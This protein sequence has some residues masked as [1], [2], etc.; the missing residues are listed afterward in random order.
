MKMM[1]PHHVNGRMTRSKP[2]MTTRY[3]AALSHVTAKPCVE[4]STQQRQPW[5]PLRVGHRR[6]NRAL[7]AWQST[8]GRILSFYLDIDTSHTNVC[9]S[10]P[11]VKFSL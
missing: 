4:Y 7:G 10:V 11:R 5:D 8:M 3:D 2:V 6:F 9:L 1:K